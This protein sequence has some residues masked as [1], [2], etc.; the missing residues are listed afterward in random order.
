MYVANSISIFLILVWCRD[1]DSEFHSK[2]KAWL[3]EMA[4]DYDCDR[5]VVADTPIRTKTK[6]SC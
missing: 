6:K 2:C 3:S 1:F 4:C 5:V